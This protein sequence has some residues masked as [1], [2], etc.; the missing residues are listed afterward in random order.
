MNLNQIDLIAVTSSP[1]LVGSLLVGINFAKGLSFSLKKPLIAV[2]HLKAHVAANYLT[3]KN[4]TPSFLA[5]IISGGHTNIV[6]VRNYTEFKLIG[7]TVDDSVGETFDKIG[8]VLNINYPAGPE[9]DSLSKKGN[10]LKYSFPKP[11]VENS[12]FDFSFSGLK[13]AVIN[14][15]RK[16]E[17][18]NKDFKIEDIAASFQEV[19][20][21]ILSEK[22]F[23]AAKKTNQKKLVICG[24]VSAN[25]KIR[26]C[27]EKEAEKNGIK[28]FMPD[29]KY[30]T[31]NAAMVAS[32][33]FFEFESGNFEKNYNLNAVSKISF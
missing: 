32:Q 11:K 29:L 4:L 8:R 31:D 25:S 12:E 2:N 27:L 9:I 10:C 13:T 19:V 16:E 15:I 23:L 18:E 24:G 14:K 5:L 20:C 1:G 28:I 21:N 17:L 26:S 22:V 6:L 3:H 7:K 30:C 33:G